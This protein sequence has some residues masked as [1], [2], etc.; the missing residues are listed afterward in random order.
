M[1]DTGMHSLLSMI[2]NWAE[3][4]IVPVVNV[5]LL[6]LWAGCFILALGIWIIQYLFGL[7]G[8]EA[9]RETKEAFHSQV[10]RGKKYVRKQR[11]ASK[12][13]KK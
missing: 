7:V 11:A 12:A 1:Q 10:V 3:G 8:N 13:K 5:S 6:T 4:I 2:I 9:D